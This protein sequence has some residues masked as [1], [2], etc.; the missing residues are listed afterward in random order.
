MLSNVFHK[1]NAHP[2]EPPS[3]PPK[4]VNPQQSTMAQ[5][6]QALPSDKEGRLALA[7]QAMELG[8]F[9]S[10]RAAAELYD[11]DWERLRDRLNGVLARRDCIPNSRKLSPYEEAAIIQ[12][13]VKLLCPTALPGGR[14]S[15]PSSQELAAVSARTA[16]D[17]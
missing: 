7:K 10:I 2:S 6:K 4:R 14:S 15:M 3:K 1:R 13:I 11:V 12:Y 8:Q 17:Q 5:P 16:V 9:Q